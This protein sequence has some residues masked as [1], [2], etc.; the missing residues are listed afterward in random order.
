M[1][2][3]GREIW[4]RNDKQRR[5]KRYRQG[6]VWRSKQKVFG[7]KKGAKRKKRN[8]RSR[9]L[10]KNPETIRKPNGRL[11]RDKKDGS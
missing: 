11:N 2:T 1:L 9:H 8:M 5:R 7:L 10:A 3:N 6:G 4:S